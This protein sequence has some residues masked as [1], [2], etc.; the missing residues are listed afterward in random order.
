MSGGL[1]KFARLIAFCG[2]CLVLQSGCLVFKS[3]DN[4]PGHVYLM[5]PPEEFLMEPGRLQPGETGAIVIGGALRPVFEIGTMQYQGEGGQTINLGGEISMGIGNLEYVREAPPDGMPEMSMGQKLWNLV[6]GWL[7]YTSSDL[8]GGRIY[9]EAQW[10]MLGLLRA[11]AGWS[12]QPGV[13]AHGPQ[14]TLGF[15][16]INHV[17]W[18]WDFDHG[19]SLTYGLSVP[20]S[21]L[22]YRSR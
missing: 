20:F 4:R 19:W 11:S 3:E 10:Q 6:V 21:L 1:A 15:L 12:L 17:R 16:H 14:L 8:S 5:E 22:Y 7:P 13:G 9:G 2:M 18:S